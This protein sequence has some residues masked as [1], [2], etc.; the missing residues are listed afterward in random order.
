MNSQIF[1]NSDAYRRALARVSDLI[2]LDPSPDSDDGRELN[3]LGLLVEAYEADH[4]PEVRAE[5]EIPEQTRRVLEFISA[6]ANAHLFTKDAA[7][8]AFVHVKA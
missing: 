6:P 5:P 3:Y 7:L 8:K 2:E 4:F 1:E